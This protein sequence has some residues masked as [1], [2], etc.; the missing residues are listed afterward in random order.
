MI[1][2]WQP[3][4]YL[5]NMFSLFNQMFCNMLCSLL[6]LLRILCY[7]YPFHHCFPGLRR[8]GK[9]RNC[10]HRERTSATWLQRCVVLVF[11]V[12]ARSRVFKHH[13]MVIDCLLLLFRMQR[14]GNVKCKRKRASQRN[15]KSL[16]F[17][18]RW[19]R[20]LHR[21]IVCLSQAIWALLVSSDCNSL[22]SRAP[23]TQSCHCLFEKHVWW[24]SIIKVRERLTSPLHFV[25]WSTNFT[26]SS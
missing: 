2:L 20:H 8:L 26:N 22:S 24:E 23:P 25:P 1:L 12:Y 5:F 6:I 19:Q 7:W 17:R 4:M 14:K 11:L 3:S 18:R 21:L 9:R 15:R 10:G 13:I 16:S